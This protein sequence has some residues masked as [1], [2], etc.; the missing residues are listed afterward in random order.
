[1][2]RA[3]RRLLPRVGLPY[4]R[5]VAFSLVLAATMPMALLGTLVYDQVDRSLAADAV[6]RT[7]RAID[8]ARAEVTKVRDD[9]DVLV[10]SY[11]DWATFAESV[12]T[13]QLEDVRTGVLDFLVERGSVDGGVVT[14]PAG[15]VTAGRPAVAAALRAA[16]GSGLPDPRFVTVDD[17]VYVVDD[18]A[19]TGGGTDV[20][21]RLLLARKLDAR[22][23]T[24]IV[25]FTGFDVAVLGADG[26]VAVTTD[27]A[28]MGPAI[29]ASATS[30][31]VVRGGDLVA[32][33]VPL[34][35]GS[36][37]HL[38]LAS[39]V[40]ALQSAAGTLPV[41]IWL[42]L[43]V[44]GLIAAV[45]AAL[46]STILRR[47]L[48]VVHDALIA[49]A[50]GRVPPAD[51]LGERDDDIARLAAGLDRLV[52]TL[53]RRESILR[54]CLEAAASIPLHVGPREAA[55]RIAIATADIFDLAGCRLVAPDG[56]PIAGAGSL[57]GK[58]APHEVEAFLGLGADGRR[59]EVATRPGAEWTDGDQASLEVMALLAGSVLAETESY[60]GAVV[61]ADRL[62]RL[63]RLQREFLRSISHNL[64][65]PL[66]T[67]EL[68]ASDLEELAPSPFVRERAEAIR[69]EERR[70]ARLVNQVLLLSRME[71]GTLLLDGEPVALAP[72]VRRV[73][74]ELGILERVEVAD[75]AAGAI[76]FTDPAA[77]EQIAWIL[78][79]NASRYAPSGPI[80][81]EILAGSRDGEPEVLLAVEDEGPGVPADERRRIFGRF[82]RGTAGATTDGT[83]LGLSVARG[84]A[85]TLG[86]DIGCRAGAIGARFEVRLPGSGPADSEGEGPV[87]AREPASA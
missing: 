43:A 73:A 44:T 69:L 46:L 30:T 86:G 24:D 7:D 17:E 62:D 33:R 67:I 15:T 29:D 39:R 63:N 42:L 20:V 22:F 38:V 51:V 54:R 85:R 84:L 56:T 25:N 3:R 34:G 35:D 10:Q 45:L 65:A 16:A 78:L 74:D 59:L 87:D 23:V 5:L 61:R 55:G 79:D 57:A 72:L 4:H 13:G 47:R 27:T 28:L 19:V 53:D 52:R 6:A 64:R 21:G 11:A 66:A 36:P 70:L 2:T 68:A 60:E 41:L 58:D 71:T 76:A 48:G 83:G 37:E 9:L 1:M 31:G 82:V 49:V 50:D 77:T 75:R 32:R 80:H 81:V 18:D 12:R 26:S 8:G 40:S 14:S